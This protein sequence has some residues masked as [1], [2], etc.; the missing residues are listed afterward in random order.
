MANRRI[1][2]LL[3]SGEVRQAYR[4]SLLE[5]RVAKV[6]TLWNDGR[7]ADNRTRTYADYGNSGEMDDAGETLQ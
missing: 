2:A 6:L 5:F 1:C 3:H 4:P 7:I